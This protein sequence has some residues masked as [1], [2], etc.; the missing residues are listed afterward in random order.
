[1]EVEKK[2][3]KI[4]IEGIKQAKKLISQGKYITPEKWNPPSPEKENEYIEKYGFEEFAKW[5]LAYEEESNPETKGAYKFIYTS[6]FQ[7]VDRKGLVAIRQRAGQFGY[8]EI[9]EQAGILL[10]LIDEQ[11]NDNQ[12]RLWNVNFETKVDGDV[13]E[14]I[15]STSDLDREKE[16]VN[17]IGCRFDNYLKNPIVLFNHDVTKPLGRCEQLFISEDRII[18]KTRLNDDD[19]LDPYLKSIINLIKNGTLRA[20]SIGFIPIKWH[21]EQKEVDGEK[22]EVKIFDEWELV[23]YSIVAI[24]SNPNALR[25]AGRTISRQNMEKIKQ[26]KNLLLQVVSIIEEFEKYEIIDNIE[27]PE[28]KKINEENKPSFI[29]YKQ[30]IFSLLGGKD[31]RTN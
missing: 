3:L 16:I 8:N 4:N 28:E 7:N 22:F 6:D 12:K 17:P 5:H 27:Q 30:F 10:A 1:M 29:D 13:I 24:P 18:A 15:I 25:K 31:E 9:F 20:A 2:E 26:M 21:F 19:I 14:F 11:E 23:E